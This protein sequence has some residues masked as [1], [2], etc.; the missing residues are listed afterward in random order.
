MPLRVASGSL[1]M[2]RS[3]HFCSFF[4][5]LLFASLRPL[6]FYPSFFS[7]FQDE[8]DATTHMIALGPNS[9]FV[10]DYHTITC[11]V[12]GSISFDL[13]SE[14]F[15]DSP[16]SCEASQAR[17]SQLNSGQ[18]RSSQVMPGQAKSAQVRLSRVK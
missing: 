14:V 13:H 8:F 6:C 5:F 3:D 7:V 17:S 12:E 1:P 4:S 15:I 2:V 9:A 16:R 18:A 11:L 10:S